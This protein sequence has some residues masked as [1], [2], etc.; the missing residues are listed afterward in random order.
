MNKQRK[1]GEIK[2]YLNVLRKLSKG[3]V[4]ILLMIVVTPFLSL[5]LFLIESVRYQDV[6]E[7]I[8]EI[9]DCSAIST[10]GNYDPFLHDRFGLVAVDQTTDIST[11]YNGYLT[12]N[13]ES[14]GNEVTI[15]SINATGQYALSNQGVF[16]QQVHEFS[17]INSMIEI[18]FEGFDLQDLFDK[19]NDKIDTSG[20][21]KVTEGGNKAMDILDALKPVVIDING[22]S[23]PEE[24]DPIPSL[25]TLCTDYTNTI[26]PAKEAR[27]EFLPKFD[28]FRSALATARANG[29]SNPY[30]DSAVQSAITD[31]QSSMDAY[32][33][34]V[35]TSKEKFTALTGRISTLLHDVGVL[36]DAIDELAGDTDIAEMLEA[37]SAFIADF[38]TV[39]S[40]DAFDSYMNG[41]NASFDSI[42]NTIDQINGSTFSE[43]GW[44]SN[45][46]IMM[47]LATNFDNLYSS[48]SS[49]VEHISTFFGDDSSVGSISKYLKLINKIKNMSVLYDQS[50]NSKI[51]A[52]DMAVAVDPNGSASDIMD[53]IND[54][55]SACNDVIDTIEHPDIFFIVKIVKAAAKFVRALARMIR[56]VFRWI[57]EFIDAIADIINRVGGDFSNII[58]V[59]YEKLI[60][61]GYA[62]YNFSN[63][64]NYNTGKSSLTGHDFKYDGNASLSHSFSGGLSALGDLASGSTVTVSN[65]TRF[66]GA[67]LEYIQNGLGTEVQNQVITFIE[68]YFMRMALDVAAVF[69]DPDLTPIADGF[70]P[71][72]WAVYLIVLL[73]EPFLDCILLVNG[74]ET[75]LFKG[76]LYLSPTGIGAF[77]AELA[78]VTGIASAAGDVLGMKSSEVDALLEELEGTFGS[79]GTI[80]NIGKT[81]YAEQVF[82]MLLLKGNETTMIK[83]IQNL[84]NME[85]KTNDP[86]FDLNKAYTYVQSDVNFTLTPMFNV[87]FA[88]NGYV[89]GSNVRIVG[90]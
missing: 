79:S 72:T 29:V 53:A 66:K 24:G 17:E 34:A 84:V 60:V 49:A 64:T 4:T 44:N 40:S 25:Q 27:D 80:P 75:P 21:D 14:I 3:T 82:L 77:I 18:I 86:N 83:R 73:V 31:M 19:L 52:A 56:A 12:G 39:I 87:G 58:P 57:G 62:T 30:T 69:T 9:E 70:P 61:C 65:D 71:F 55:V 26:T 45:D 47:N 8:Y 37:A 33:S 85:A 54:F 11:L 88:N 35:A 89:T 22:D 7:M 81:K 43:I 46:S 42:I 74:G 48:L 15:N 5:T 6:I 63:R 68:L 90:Y 13:M 67:E 1:I 51:S 36:Q 59:L 16:E 50:L 20:L 32:R 10:L 23:E 2:H 78:R 38:N 41:N 76:N 28:T